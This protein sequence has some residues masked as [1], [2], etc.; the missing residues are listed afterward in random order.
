[1]EFNS[2]NPVGGESQLAKVAGA[3]DY[4]NTLP[5][6]RNGDLVL[7]LDGVN[8]VWMQ[9]RPGVLIERYFDI[10]RRATARIRARLG[11]KAMENDKIGQRILFLAQKSCWPREEGSPGCSAVP[12]S[13]LPRNVY[14]LET[15]MDIGNEKN[16]YV[17]FRPRHL[18][19]GVGLGDVASLRSLLSHALEKMTVDANFGSAQ[20]VFAQI[21]EE[22]EYQREV[23]RRQDM[24][25]VQRVGQLLKSLIVKESSVLGSLPTQRLLELADCPSSEFGIGLDYEGLLGHATMYA[26]MES[27]WLR[28]NET[29]VIAEASKK[30]NISPVKVSRVPEDI[31]RSLTPFWS[32][33]GAKDGLPQNLGW[34]NVPLY[35]NLW[36]GNVPAIIHQN[37]NNEGAK[38][39]WKRT[40]FHS[41]ARKLLDVYINE[42]YRPV[43]TLRDAG[44]EVAYWS[45]AFNKWEFG[46]TNEEQQW[47]QW[48]EVCGDYQEEIFGDGKGIWRPPRVD[49]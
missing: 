12:D 36:T 38:D 27:E 29:E 18:N 24:G 3:L 25:M 19:F 2:S 13:P 6:E 11:Q 20:D 1:M 30:Q 31:T 28:H 22:Q 49:Y 43:A 32:A 35:T 42:P 34:Q 40:W 15:D 26:E 8:D 16:P 4:I 46:T 10:N 5:P 14:G 37:T 45:E 9:L 21:F 48:E 44:H 7:V 33:N 17:K 23:I 41:H 39:A 47:I